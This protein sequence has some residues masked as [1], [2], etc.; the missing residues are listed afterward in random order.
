V[1]STGIVA[2]RTA[3]K[4]SAPEKR[5][6]EMVSIFFSMFSIFLMSELLLLLLLSAL[7]LL[8]V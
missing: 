4:R 7:V 6:L 5:I 2:D 3:H 1:T 8:H